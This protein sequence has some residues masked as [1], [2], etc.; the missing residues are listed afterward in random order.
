MIWTEKSITMNNTI[1]SQQAA[2]TNQCLEPPTVNIG[3][4]G[5]ILSLISIPFCLI[6]PTSLLLSCIGASY[7]RTKQTTAGIIISAV[8]M[9]LLLIFVFSM[10]VGNRQQQQ[11]TE[12]QQRYTEQQ[13][14]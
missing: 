7:R 11:Y 9:L 2:A 13:D 6:S 14:A 10:C 12:E 4:L 5:F 8:T 3:K 1:F